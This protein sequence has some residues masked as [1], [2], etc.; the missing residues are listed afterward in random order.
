MP[1]NVFITGGAGYVG[2]ALIPFLLDGGYKVTVYDL[3][4]Y[5]DIFKDI[6]NPNLVQI[7][8]DIRDGE[9]LKLASKGADVFIHLACVSNDPS[10]ELN[11]DLGKSINYD[12]F[13]GIIRAVSENNIKRFIFASSSSV[14]G[15]KNGE[16]TEETDPSPMTDYAKYKWECERLLQDSG[17]KYVIVRPATVC[18][19]APRLRLDLA[20]NILTINA[21][22]NKVINIF[23]GSQLRPNI[24]IKDMIRIYAVLLEAPTNLINRQIFNAGCQN[25]TVESIAYLI[26][27]TLGGNDIKLVKTETNDNRSYH[28]NSEK[29]K[30]I[31]G[32]DFDYSV[33]EAILS[34]QDA[35]A[36]G[37]I[38]DGLNNPLHHNIKMMQKI[39]LK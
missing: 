4:I 20:V 1:K 21:L 28:I 38:R 34:I 25:M 14:Y 2:S 31:L 8:G 9:K 37:L 12:S 6:D 10:F 18:G 32:F 23:G 35:F 27:E 24:N 5:G 15:I 29:I 26:K 39:N 36:G 3:Y 16:V 13:P 11:P 19:Y 22:I 7:K 33:A 30:N 17:I